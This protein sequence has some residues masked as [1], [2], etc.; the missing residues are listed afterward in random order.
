LRTIV[1]ADF[2]AIP[3]HRSFKTGQGI[4]AI[5]IPAARRCIFI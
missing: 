2:N 3:D 5:V 4:G 1:I